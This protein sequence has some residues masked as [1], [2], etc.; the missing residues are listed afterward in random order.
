[1]PR[2]ELITTLILA[3]SFITKLSVSMHVLSAESKA[4]ASHQRNSL[5]SALMGFFFMLAIYTYFMF[6]RSHSKSAMSY[7]ITSLWLAFWAIAFVSVGII[8]SIEANADYHSY[9]STKEK[10]EHILNII[11]T[12]VCALVL[13]GVV[14]MRLKA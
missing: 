11:L 5:M 12:F 13:S 3:V 8:L 10:V 6:F 2:L 14:Y 1:M 7:K 9:K 4:V